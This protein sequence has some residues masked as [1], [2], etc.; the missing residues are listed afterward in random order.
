LGVL[1]A[2]F[3][4]ASGLAWGI[5]T[6]AEQ[7][8]VVRNTLNL[9]KPI[10]PV[11]QPYVAKVAVLAD[12]WVDRAD[13]VATSA[14]NV[15][16]TKV[17]EPSRDKDGKVTLFGVVA[18]SRHIAGAEL[19]NGYAALLDYSDRAVDRYLPELKEEESSKIEKKEGKGKTLRGLSSKV[20]RRLA[21]RAELRYKDAR[22]FSAGSLKTYVRVDVLEYAENGYTQILSSAK[23]L[24]ARGSAATAPLQSFAA[25]KSKLLFEL[26]AK[27][28]EYAY[29]RYQEAYKFAS[30]KADE[31]GVPVIVGKAKEVSFGEVSE[32]VLVKLNIQKKNEQFVVVE[33]KLFDLS[34]TL[35]SL[36]IT[37]DLKAN[38]EQSS[39]AN[40]SAPVAAH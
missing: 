13:A 24:Y 37:K 33:R 39:S 25:E 11:V 1:R 20:S 26:I 12:P 14:W 10:I 4:Y 32:Y 35:L 38:K 30:K 22:T 40:Q 31:F 9:A 27:Y 3:Q 19:K 21:K 34:R 15:V 2:S 28:R 5:Y 18:Q 36:I 6:R 8:P 17:I 23:D 29:Q 7:I 16:Q